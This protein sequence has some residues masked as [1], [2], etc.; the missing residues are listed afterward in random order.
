M[1]SMAGAS[2]AAAATSSILDI[3]PSR[4]RPQ[5]STR[6][7]PIN[8]A[9]PVKSARFIQPLAMAY[10]YDNRSVLHFPP[11]SGPMDAG[12]SSVPVPKGLLARL[13]YAN[14]VCVLTA[15]RA[16]RANA[17]TISWLTPTD[18]TGTFVCS[19]KQTRHTAALA[20]H[21]GQVFV[22]NVPVAGHEATVLAGGG[23]SGAAGDKLAA[24][25]LPLC[26]PGWT[27]L[28]AADRL[29]LGLPP[30]AAVVAVASEAVADKAVFV[31]SEAAA[32][33]G[34][35]PASPPAGRP[36][37]KTTATAAARAAAALAA[38]PLF[39]WAGAV[40]HIVCRVQ[41]VTD[42]HGHFLLTGTLEAGWARAAYWD[43]RCFRPRHARHPPSVP[44]LPFLGWPHRVEIT[45]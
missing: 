22:L 2:R 6:D 26:R 4:G 11:F 44:G 15:S 18:N 34:T 43:G 35:V 25:A 27:A 12:S 45:R 30:M 19:M 3:P 29:A 9:G 40:A 13:L 10:R 16:G 1:S 36:P 24:L 20:A 8:S 14:P 33:S 23:C 38:A 42:L 31:A 41:T 32:G 37:K 21:P 39:A 5:P 28:A 17:M 7:Q